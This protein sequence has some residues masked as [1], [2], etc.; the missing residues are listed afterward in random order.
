MSQQGANMR[1]LTLVLGI[2]TAV[3]AT[4]ELTVDQRVHDFTNLASTYAKRYAPYEWKRQAVGFDLYDIASW[5]TRVRAAKDDL[6]FLEICAEYVARLDDTHSSFSSGSTF[7]AS[8]GISL[9]IYDGKVLIET[10]NRAVLPVSQYP[11]QMGDE[12]VSVDG[13]PVEQLITEFS[14]FRRLGHSVATR[15]AVADLISFRAQSVIPRAVELGDSAVV[16]VRRASGDLET[17]TLP[18]T[19]TGVPVRSIGPVPAP[20]RAA[21]AAATAAVPDY[22]RELMEMR[23]WSLPEGDHLLRGTTFENDVEQERRYV[24]G[25]GSRFPV[26]RAGLPSNFVQRVGNGAADFHFSGTYEARGMRIGYLRIPNFAPLNLEAAIQELEREVRFF[27]ENTDGLVVDVMRNTGGGCY[28][29][30]VAARLI[31]YEF[32]FFGEEIRATQGRVNGLQFAIEAARRQNAP[33]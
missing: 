11:F 22:L 19:K 29:L 16:E 17:Y 10:I 21:R 4:A 20:K 5:L 14:R 2:A 30:D 8:L 28:M 12:L 23:N 6:E 33:T 31:P 7:A 13:K 24:L 15:R 3:T 32:Y 1:F 26:F 18:W 27:Q 9:D 25:L